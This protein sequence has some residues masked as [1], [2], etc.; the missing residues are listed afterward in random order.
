[1]KKWKANKIK[2]AKEAE[3]EKQIMNNLS[4]NVGLIK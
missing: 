3:R 2:K 1:M 4:S